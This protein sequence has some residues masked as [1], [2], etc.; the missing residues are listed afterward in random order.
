MYPKDAVTKVQGHFD[1]RSAL[2][3]NWK[4]YTSLAGLAVLIVIS[5]IMSPTFLSPFNIV[6]VATQIAAP[7][8]LAVGMTFVILTGGIDLSVGSLLA[9]SGVIIA[10]AAPVIG[11]PLAVLLAILLGTLIGFFHGICITRFRVP[12]FIVTLAGLSAYK[13]LALIVTSSASIPLHSE[14]FDYLGAGRIGGTF[15]LLLSGL[16]AALT[17]VHHLSTRRKYEAKEQ[18]KKWITIL[19]VM[20]CLTLFGVLAKQAG[21][22]PVQVLI[23]LTLFALAWFVLNKTVF[24]R[25]MYAIGGNPEAAR[26]AGVKVKRGLVVIYATAGFLAAIAGLLVATRLGSGT[27][28]VGTLSELDA[29][30]AV[31]IGGTSL[32]GGV[33]T[34]GGT[35]IGVFLI[36]IL[37]NLL[38]L[39]NITADMQ[40]VFKGAIILGAVMLDAKLSKK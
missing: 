20:A 4:S 27:P 10:I 25:E 22:V 17:L 14:F 12:P 24:G 21:G 19:G 11:W 31:V 9:L 39:L 5:A 35:I 33:G 28:Q 15:V 6:N 1:D 34:L 2:T 3:V 29:I 30:A 38:S 40:M 36:G 13:G 7:G 26:L 18:A 16:I 23:F 32:M 8:I 37:N